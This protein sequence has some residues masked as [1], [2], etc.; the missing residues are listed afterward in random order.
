[1]TIFCVTTQNICFD[2][3]KKYLKTIF[4]SKVFSS[5]LNPNKDFNFL[6]IGTSSVEI[7]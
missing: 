2:S 7:L 1:M 5:I 4:P 3:E 6:S